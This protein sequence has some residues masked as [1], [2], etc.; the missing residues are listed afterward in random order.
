MLVM[1]LKAAQTQWRDL[2]LRTLRDSRKWDTHK[3]RGPMSKLSIHISANPEGLGPLL[4]QCAQAKSPIAVIYSLNQNIDDA[5]QHNSPETK[6]IYRRQSDVFARLPGDFWLGD[7]AQSAT[8]WLIGVRD[9]GDKQRT[10]V[11]N[12]KLN[13]ADWYDPLNEPVIEIADPTN[14]AQVADAVRKA[15][16]LNTWMITALNIANSNG[17]LKLA[18]FSFP[19]GSPSLAKWNEINASQIQVPP[20]PE[21]QAV[22]WYY[23][24]PALRLGKQLGAVL[25]LHAYWEDRDPSV[26]RRDAL[27]YRDLI[28]LLPSDAQLPIVISEASNGNGYG[29]S[30]GKGHGQAWI[31]DMASWDTELMKDPIILAGCAFQVGRN[32]ESQIPPDVLAKYGDYISAH[33][34]PSAPAPSG[35]APSGTAPSG[36]APSGT[37]PSGTTPSGTTPS[38]PPQP[39]GTSADD[40]VVLSDSGL[41]ITDSAGHVWSLGDS[42]GAGRRILQDGAPFAGGQGVLLLFHD[43]KVFT[44]NSQNEWYVATTTQWQAVPGDPRQRAVVFG[45]HGSA[46]LGDLSPQDSLIMKLIANRVTGYKFMTGHSP[47]HYNTIINVLNIPAANCMTRLF[48]DMQGHA[49]QPKPADFVN[50]M[51]RAI[52][53]AW[54]VGVRW[55]ELHNEPNLFKEWKASWGGATAFVAWA[56]EVIDRLKQ[57]WD[58]INIVS[59]GLSPHDDDAVGQSTDSWIGV[60]DTEGLFAIC[61]AVGAHAYWGNRQFMLTPQDGLNYQR[62][63][64]HT[65]KPIWLTEFSNNQTSDSDLEK[66]QQYRDYLSYLRQN[67]PRVERAYC[68]VMSGQDF[69][70]SHEAWVRHDA[71]TAIPNGVI[72]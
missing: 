2:S 50:D 14:P 52:Q 42:D 55:Y 6:W 16:W 18:L 15:Q 38:G 64:A 17:G 27:R 34:T 12:W 21:C 63:F 60:F 4:L 69:E 26:D 24:L 9:P 40:T 13:P 44:Q 22:V 53:D 45:V 31:N 72:A 28:S 5:I 41:S 32:V 66:G 62:Y 7:P 33:P 46:Q 48:M 67:E 37:A 11:D 43:Q 19:T 30:K 51:A 39:A 3:E 68:F 25:S 54:T 58:G 10:Q 71:T 57:Q 56:K 20:Q 61:D 29:V 23:L 70:N 59:P 8:S 49:D 65:D 35:T 47:S 1:L 36:T